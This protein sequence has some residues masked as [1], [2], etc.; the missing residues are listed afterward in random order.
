MHAAAM[1]IKPALLA[2]RFLMLLCLCCVH[3]CIAQGK[4]QRIVCLA[5][6]ITEMVYALGCGERIAGCSLQSTV[7]PQARQLPDVGPYMDPSLEKILLLKPDACI[8]IKDGTPSRLIQRLKQAHIA[9]CVLEIDSFDEL[10]AAVRT[11]GDVLD[12]PQNAQDVIASI[13]DSL[14]KINRRVALL[15]ASAARPTVLFQ[16][17]QYPVIAVSPQTF[18]GRLIELAGGVNIIDSGRRSPYP[19][20]GMEEIIQK[21]PHVIIIAGMGDASKDAQAVLRW[22]RWPQ[23]SAVRNNR[24]F[25]VDS[26]LFTRPALRSISAAEQLAGMLFPSRRTLPRENTARFN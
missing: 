7:P 11:L 3:A 2:M 19:V 8:A 22:K 1:R 20:I 21:D 5:P 24:V 25:A 9:V 12:V 23:L 10:K 17:Q 26:D 4:A 16:L 14:K 15:S 6:S 18:G 13:D